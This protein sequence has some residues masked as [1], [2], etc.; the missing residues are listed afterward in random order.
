MLEAENIRPN[1]N[2]I[3]II[4]R[5]WEVNLEF[6]F[7]GNEAK[8]YFYLLHICNSLFWKNP[9]RHSLRQIQLGTG[10]SINSIKSAQKR[11]V[12]SGL[13]SIKNGTAGNRLDLKNKTEYL[14]NTVSMID[15]DT[16]THPDTDTDT[17]PDSPTDSQPDTIRKQ[18][19]TKLKELNSPVSPGEQI[20]YQKFVDLYHSSCP[21]MPA[22]STLSDS[23]KK[24]IKARV[25]EFGKQKVAEMLE[26]AGK[27]RFLSGDNTRKWKANLD[28]LLK[29]ANFVK[30]LDGCYDTKDSKFRNSE[31]K[32]YDNKI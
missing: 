25:S 3:K 6:D 23:R 15:T 13:L 4:N 26:R 28:W 31:I 17:H 27:S 7:T 10:I 8:L 19:E 5:F 18:E 16:D 2:Y 1:L 21:D 29:P 12:E 30:V 24:A 32:K 9:F 11:L 14:L 22:I 20:D